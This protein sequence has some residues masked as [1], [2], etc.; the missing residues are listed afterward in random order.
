MLGSHSSGPRAADVHPQAGARFA[1]IGSPRDQ[2][3]RLMESAV[4]VEVPKLD[5]A[6]RFRVMTGDAEI[7]VRGTAFDVV[8]RRDHLET[9]RVLRG[10]EEER[11]TGRAVVVL[12]AGGGWPTDSEPPPPPG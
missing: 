3:V 9:V 6:Q 12:D 1:R 5:P 10:G 8:A 11:A 7:E 4:T 2:I